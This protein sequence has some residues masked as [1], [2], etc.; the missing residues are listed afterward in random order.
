[1]GPNVVPGARESSGVAMRAAPALWVQMGEA[2]CACGRGKPRG[3]R[4]L[5]CELQS[6]TWGLQTLAASTSTTFK[7]VRWAWRFLVLYN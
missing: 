2:K 3:F 7:E 6:R 1:M 5:T 4:K